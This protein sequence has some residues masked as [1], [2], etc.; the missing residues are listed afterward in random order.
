M[1]MPPNNNPWQ[2]AYLRLLD[3][4]S[5]IQVDDAQVDDF[6]A[7]MPPRL[8]DESYQDWLERGQKAGMPQRLTDEAYED[9]LERG[10]RL[11]NVIP[12]RKL[13]FTYLTEIQRYAADTRETEDE[14]PKIA[15]TTVNQQFR[16]KV[17][18]LPGKQEK[19]K[20][21]VEALG[22]ASTRYARKVIG[23]AGEIGKDHLGEDSKDHLIALIRLNEDGDGEVTLD[24]T[25]IVRQALLRP[26]IGLADEQTDA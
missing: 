8:E 7:A 24:N 1:S 12:F 25:A 9:W 20:L 16:L 10:K 2:E 4:A 3:R 5:E 18:P 26:I 14:L 19:L 22:L 13:R 15:L 21:T 23:I 6:L 11:T 17:T